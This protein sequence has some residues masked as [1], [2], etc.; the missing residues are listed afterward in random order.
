MMLSSWPPRRGGGISGAMGALGTGALVLFGKTKYILAALKLTKLASLGSMLLTVGTYSMFF[1]WPYAVGIVGLTVIH[2][3]GHALVMRHFGIP[4][5]PMVFVPFIGA[6]V[7]MNQQPRDAYEEALI[8]LGGPVLGSLGA[9]AVAIGAHMTD[10]QLLYAVAD[11]GFMVNLFNLMPIG[12]MDGGRITGALSPYAGVVGLGVGGGLIYTGA[13]QNPIFYLVMMAGTYSTFMRFYDPHSVP[14]NYYRI[15][16][17]Q[18]VGIGGA[19][20]GLIAALIAAMALNDRSKKNPE[21]LQRDRI[22]KELYY[23]D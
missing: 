2:E 10:S 14:R 17:S 15:T 23:V 1:G 21:Q 16:A 19:Y 6:S 7:A 12:S 13:I 8:A 11:F 22:G 20:V 4:F 18:K 5:S 9:G 3:S